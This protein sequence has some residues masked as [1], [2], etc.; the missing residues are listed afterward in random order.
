MGAI[1]DPR[2]AGKRPELK[3]KV[4]VPDVLLNP[5]FAS[6]ELQFY[7]ASQFP[8]TYHGRGFAAEHGS[9]NRDPR[10]GYEVITIPMEG[11]KATGEYEDFLTGFVLPGRQGV[12]PSGRHRGG[13]RWIPAGLRR[14]FEYHLAGELHGSKNGSV[15]PIADA[16]FGV[17]PD[18]VCDHPG[19]R[20]LDPTAVFYPLPCA[21]AGRSRCWRSSL[22]SGIAG[23]CERVFPATAICFCAARLAYGRALPGALLADRAI[24]S[25]PNHRIEERLMAF[26]RWLMPRAAGT[27]GTSRTGFGMVLEVAYLFC[28]PLVPLGLLALYAVGQRNHVAGFWL[29][30]LVATYLC[31]AITP[32]VPAYPPRDLAGGQPRKRVRRGSSIA[33]FSSMEVSMPSPFPAPMWPLPSRFH[34]RCCITRP[35]WG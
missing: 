3:S 15:R 30:V 19:S 21:G 25:G 23:A 16:H 26:D 2:Q 29:V 8:S 20:G 22:G 14:R 10:G 11:G 17:D 6:L 34:W 32:F 27:S 31:Y 13:Q 33:G 7:E 1:Q 24:F 35:S 18:R 9:W 4:I 28:Y 5:H 12:G